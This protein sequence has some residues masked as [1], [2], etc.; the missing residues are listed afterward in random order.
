LLKI[1]T[2]SVSSFSAQNIVFFSEESSAKKNQK[3]TYC[4]YMHE[5]NYTNDY[6]CILDQELSISFERQHTS[7]PTVNSRPVKRVNPA[8]Y[9]VK[10][11]FLLCRIAHLEIMKKVTTTLPWTPLEELTKIPNIPIWWGRITAVTDLPSQNS[12][13]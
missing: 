3:F 2:S 4:C 7:L 13:Y 12:T 8:T 1:L 5:E 9:R 10:F 6:N 11:C